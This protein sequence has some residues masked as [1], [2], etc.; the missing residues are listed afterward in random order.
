MAVGTIGTAF[1]DIQGRTD[2][3]NKSVE[4][5]VTSSIKGLAKKAAEIFV[6][7][8]IIEKGFDF[9][10]DAVKEA[11]A[12]RKVFAQT[13]AVIASTGGVAGVSAEEVKKLAERMAGVVGIPDDA[14]ASVENMLLTF[15]NIRNEVGKGNDIFN[16]ATQTVLDLSVALGEDTKGAAIQ[17]GKALQDPVRGM[18]A[19]R[20]VGVAFTVE[21]QDQVKALVAS[22]NQLGAQKLILA[23]LSKEFGGSAAAQATA[24]QKLSAIYKV[25][26]ENVGGLLLPAV[27]VA[28]RALGSFLPA[29]FEQ[30]S[31]VGAKLSPV[32][33]SVVA[34]LK[35]LGVAAFAQIAAIGKQLGPVAASVAAALKPIG[36][37]VFDQVGKAAIRLVPVFKTLGAGVKAFV[38]A[39]V[40]GRKEGSGFIGFM[41]EI[42]K[43]I[44]T[45][46]PLLVVIR[47]IPNIVDGF[48]GIPVDGGPTAKFFAAIGRIARGAFDTVAKA[49]NLLRPLLRGL[50]GLVTGFVDSFVTGDITATG[51]LGFVQAIGSALH[52][53]ALGIGGLVTSSLP[54]FLA[55]FDGLPADGGNGAGFFH[56]IGTAARGVVDFFRGP[57]V[58]GAID[59][60]KGKF[61]TLAN[62]GV[63]IV[64]FFKDNEAAASG[65]QIALAGVAAAL[66]TI[67]IANKVATTIKSVSAGLHALTFALPALGAAG[68]IGIIAAAVVALGAAGF[69]AYKRFKPFHDL[70]DKFGE[71]CKRNVVPVALLTGAVL[72]LTAAMVANPIG[73][74]V[75]ALVA[76]GVAVFAAYK[77]FKP[78]HDVVDA[79]GR[80]IGKAAVATF[81]ALRV[82]ISKTGEFLGAVGTKLGPVA[83][84]ISAVI[85]SI[86]SFLVREAPIVGGV[87]A[88]IATTIAR[89][90]GPM[91]AFVGGVIADFFRFL[92]RAAPVAFAV[93]KRSIEI[94][95]TV[96]GVI[97]STAKTV[98]SAVGEAFTATVGFF[99]RIGSA[100]GRSTPFRFLIEQAQHFVAFLVEIA[101][102]VR[103]ALGHVV[104]VFIV[105]GKAIGDAFRIGF[106]VVSAEVSVVIALIKLLATGV[107]DTVDVIRGFWKRFGD[108]I[109]R[110]VNDVV[111]PLLAILSGTFRVVVDIFKIAINVVVFLWRKWGDDLLRILKGFLDPI[112][113]VV[114]LVVNTIANVIRLVLDLINGDWSKAWQAAK[115]IVGGAIDFM[116]SI[117]KGFIDIA[118]GLLGGIGD[119][120]SGA[121]RNAWDGLAN[122]VGPPL[123][124]VVGFVTK[125]PGRILRASAG[126]GRAIAGLFGKGWEGL[127]KT[128]AT[129]V[130]AVV[131]FVGGLPHRLLSFG[132][133]L[134]KGIGGLFGAGWE[135]LKGIAGQAVNDLVG[136]ILAFP[137]QLFAAGRSFRSAVAG[138]FGSAWSAVELTVR[139]AVDA[140]VGFVVGLPVRIGA[141]GAALVGVVGGLFG[142]AWSLLRTVVSDAVS[143]VVDAV[144]G[145]ASGIGNAAVGVIGVVSGLFGS[146]WDALKVVAG[147]AVADIVGFVAG[148]PQQLLTAAAGLAGIIGQLFGAAW[149]DLKIL[150]NVAVDDIIGFVAGLPKQILDLTSVVFAAFQSLGGEILHGILDGLQAA[151]S[152]AT[153]FAKT[154]GNAIID[155]VNDQIIGRINAIAITIPLPGFLGG[156]RKIAPPDIPL[157]P[158]LASGGIAKANNPLAAFIGDNKFRDEA[159][160]PLPPGFIKAMEIIAKN[161]PVSNDG[162]PLTGPVTII[163]SPDGRKTYSELARAMRSSQFLAGAN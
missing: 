63:A 153:D 119:T 85:G 64:K 114:K 24:T 76:L 3:F 91:F 94:V 34:A 9:F 161:G 87:I 12:A 111:A 99:K 127:T 35:P 26:K 107:G 133:D 150:V 69:L 31:K 147:V 145:L 144:S 53:L 86:V 20:R 160:V 21:Q 105:I 15:T 1:V 54:N 156:D 98:A 66:G 58:S 149:D 40:T 72:G 93:L 37:A 41:S 113:G 117:V 61:E 116:I 104:A 159:V 123:D 143:G 28:A 128:T 142:D 29:A 140:V 152:F 90:L 67:L 81:D 13:N 134:A 11:D 100:I 154:I 22:G 38:V 45:L 155:L 101:P 120:V 163:E 7:G 148:L 102:Q 84:K 71:F 135:T 32:V 108:D 5:G 16:Q 109:L 62:G 74:I 30:I 121:F 19:L 8:F 118:A 80:G 73:L 131:G 79:V 60:V 17:L 125:L 68:P 14:I 23:E 126:L 75:A 141:A 46:I 112:V 146:A 95:G 52:S 33:K 55:G 158:R 129:A 50:G 6:A 51:F 110:V 25:F 92:V 42:G 82:A 103:E 88:D 157:I 137:A 139:S 162:R 36:T 132:A 47:N 59:V 2:N 77:R 43:A 138:L 151:G 89:I 4:G 44:G 10:K 27:D 97:I 78:F 70:V 122:I 39:L 83:A 18:T 136:F 124:A 115:D 65:L 130:N 57:T 48:K 96:L 56:A 106:E 49:G